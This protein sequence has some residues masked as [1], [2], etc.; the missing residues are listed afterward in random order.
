MG[1]MKLRP[2]CEKPL[3]VDYV[4]DMCFYVLDDG[5]MVSTVGDAWTLLEKGSVFRLL[6]GMPYSFKNV[7]TSTSKL[8]YVLMKPRT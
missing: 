7:G 6:S 2:D 5:L 3:A 1:I 4:H 8:F